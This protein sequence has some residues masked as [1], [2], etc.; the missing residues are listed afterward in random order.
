MRWF[1]RLI[2]PIIVDAVCA[3]Q[4]IGQK[5]KKYSSFDATK[6]IAEGY[7]NESIAQIVLKKTVIAKKNINREI[8]SKSDL[9]NLF[10]FQLM[11]NDYSQKVEILEIGGACGM[12][13][14]FADYH[15]P[16]WIN[17]YSV[18]ETPEMV[19]YAKQ[20][21]LGERL[22][23]F[24]DLNEAFSHKKKPDILILSGSLQYLPNSMQVFNRLLDQGIP[25]IY[26]TRLPLL[27]QSISEEYGFQTSRLKHHGPGEMQIEN[28]KEIKT[29]VTYLPLSV[30]KESIHKHNYE[31]EYHF[32]ESSKYVL[33]FEG[34]NQ[35]LRV[36]G[37][38]LSKNGKSK[39]QGRPRRTL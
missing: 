19:K 32:Y 11:W 20:E 5:L 30:I 29:P 39:L 2:P 13:Y 9:Q 16:E 25:F 22:F 12:L 33:N 37:F 28:D 7:S 36:F 35:I 15:F 31:I 3:L 4:R 34:S 38:I 27:I 18:V 6:N 21:F 14:F 24:Y 17:K 10:F 23:F 26:L 1:A 8:E